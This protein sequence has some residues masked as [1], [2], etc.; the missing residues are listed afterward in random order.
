MVKVS[1]KILEICFYNSFVILVQ[2]QINNQE[3][4]ADY[5]KF[6]LN[7]TKLFTG[8]EEIKKSIKIMS[9]ICIFL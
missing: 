7:L 6:R 9:H 2:I 8:Y 3:K 5:L 1:F 4:P